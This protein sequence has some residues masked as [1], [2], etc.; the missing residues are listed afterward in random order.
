[1]P[2]SRDVARARMALNFTAL[3]SIPAQYKPYRTTVLRKLRTRPIVQQRALGINIILHTAIARQYAPTNAPPPFAANASL[4]PPAHVAPSRLRPLYTH[5]QL[6]STTLSPS[7]RSY[8]FGV[9]ARRVE[10]TATA[11]PWN[12]SAQLGEEVVRW[13]QERE[14]EEGKVRV[15]YLQQE[16]EA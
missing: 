4:N 14:E 12:E 2:T 6:C 8:R 10:D 9:A 16:S 15:H 5:M 13:M 7:K 3:I 11:D 1:M